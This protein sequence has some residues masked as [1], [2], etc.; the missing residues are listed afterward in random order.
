MK[1]LNKTKQNII[2]DK[3]KVA[4]SFL[5]RMVGLLNRE[6]FSEGEALVITRCNSIHMFFMK[7]AI[8]VVFVSKENVVVGLVSDIR[9]FQLSRIYFRSSYVVELPSSA[10]LSAGISIGDQIEISS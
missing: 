2:A 3:A 6:S 10:I 9:P 5:T 7:F 4:D 8:D 1:I